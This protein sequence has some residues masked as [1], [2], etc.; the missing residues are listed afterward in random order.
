MEYILNNKDLFNEMI[1]KR[2]INISF[3]EIEKLSESRK[4]SLVKTHNLQEQK[5]KLAKEIGF[6]KA[7]NESVDD[8]MK[9]SEIIK[10]QLPA[11]EEELNLIEQK[12][13]DI[14]LTFPNILSPDVPT[15]KDETE[16]KEIRNSGIPRSF[17]F[18]AKQHFELGEALKN[19]DGS[20][21][22]FD[23][24]IK[25]S[26]SRFVV[27][28]EKLAKLERALVNFMLDHNTS[29]G[30]TE[31]SV[32]FLVKPHSFI[33]TGQL[34]KFEGDFFKTTDGYYLIP[35]SEVSLTNLVRETILPERDLPLR[36]TA[37]TPCF[38][39]EAGSAGR[40]TRGMIR[41]HQ[42]HKVELVS[43]CSPENSENEHEYLVETAEQILIQ[44]G[45]PFRTVL[46]CSGDTGF[47]AQKTYD[48][49]VWLPGQNRYREISSL[50][51]CG[52]FQATRME[53]KFKRAE[54]KKNEFVHT[55]NG[56]SL[57]VGRTIVAILEN[58]QTE[59]GKIEI[60][61]VLH[62]YTGFN[63]I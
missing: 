39:S 7:N 25:I 44:L 35:T 24:A 28:R 23:S 26:G 14:L 30:Y 4:S 32:P 63:I 2:N 22:D 3:E 41:Q 11:S 36:L 20:L 17:S 33:G 52:S 61:E 19:K 12:I 8:L 27:L 48:I 13:R 54:S 55:L 29:R 45:L 9:Q 46:L 16:N 1:K 21:M 37:A 56:S 60:P 5:N 57:A 59:S 40:D 43:I 47:S 50:S 10:N 51:N 49:E 31:T 42:F 58:F 6:K 38:R 15:G 62:K 53:A 34:P 18:T